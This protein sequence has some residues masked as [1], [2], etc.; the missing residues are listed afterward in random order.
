MVNTM[1]SQIP[2]QNVEFIY[3]RPKWYYIKNPHVE[4]GNNVFG[5]VLLSIGLFKKEDIAKR[6]IAPEFIGENSQLDLIPKEEKS[7]QVYLI[8]LRDIRDSSKK[9][10]SKGETSVVM[11]LGELEFNSGTV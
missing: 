7:I 4:I 3:Q 9:I 5:K 6:R 8:G 10:L 1:K 2:G 11:R